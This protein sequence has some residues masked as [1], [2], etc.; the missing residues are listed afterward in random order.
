LLRNHGVFS[1]SHAQVT[2]RCAG[3]GREHSQAAS[4]SWPVEIFH[5]MDIM[6]SLSMGVGQGDRNLPFF[7]E[8]KLY[9]EFGLFL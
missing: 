1:V 2:S 8:F 3:A 9:H 6:L 7:S 4:P 5:T